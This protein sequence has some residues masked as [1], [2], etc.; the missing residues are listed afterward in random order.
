[1][2]EQFEIDQRFCKYSRP[3]EGELL[4]N[5]DLK[6]LPECSA[7]HNEQVDNAIDFLLSNRPTFAIID[8]GRSKEERSCIWIENGHFY[9]MGYIPSDIAIHDPLEVKNYVTAYK[10]NQYM[11]QLIFAYAEKYPGKV[12]FKKHFL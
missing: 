6:N 2:S 12:F 10:S 3:E 7:L 11:V 5:N 9:G 8:K 1:M 4:Q